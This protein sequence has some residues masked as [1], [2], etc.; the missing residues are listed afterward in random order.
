[1]DTQRLREERERQGLTVYA[2]FLASGVHRDT[3]RRIEAGDRSVSLRT[4][5][6]VAAA[7]GLRL[8]LDFDS[9]GSCPEKSHT[10]HSLEED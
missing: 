4:L 5:D 7:L 9:P 2:L 8:R 6:K 1:M 3:I 10:I